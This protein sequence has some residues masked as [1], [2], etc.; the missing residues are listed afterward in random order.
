MTARTRFS[1]T[2][3]ALFLA[4]FLVAGCDS[5]GA[6]DDDAPPPMPA[7]AFE[8]QTGLF[9]ETPTTKANTVVNFTAA[10]LR[11][12]PMSLIL[13]A[14]LVVPV[15][16]TGA[17]LQADP[18]FIDGAWVWDMVTTVNGQPHEFAL[19]GTI[20]G[21]SI[22]WSMRISAGQL[23]DFELY[24]GTT[25]LASRTG[26][27]QLYYPIEGE[28]QLVLIAEFSVENEAEKE[29]TY[30]VSE[31]FEQGGGDTIR[32]AT[33]GDDRGFLWTQQEAALQHL[34]TWN[35]ATKEGSITADNFN[36]GTPG[37]WGT[38]L[39]DVDC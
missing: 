24:T 6:D 29:I 16:V 5:S 33:S 31:V 21:S 8:L 32:Y 14:N 37:C 35:A 4:V 38:D 30:T 15:G 17:A 13:T 18:K 28:R 7:A 10:A 22:D 3:C 36:G 34:V 25:D 26:S 39:H 2:R 1:L 19:T 11:V 9:S 23:D 20:E 12:W 27:W